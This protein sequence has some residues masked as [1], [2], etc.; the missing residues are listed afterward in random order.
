ME[1]V[2]HGLPLWAFTSVLK[3][4]VQLHSWK[5]HTSHWR[6]WGGARAGARGPLR[7][8]ILSFWHTKFSKRNCLGSPHPL[9]RGPRPPLREILDPPLHLIW[10]IHFT[11][12]DA[13]HF[14]YILQ[15]VYI[16]LCRSTHLMM[17]MNEIN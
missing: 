13:F 14:A 16:L 1:R 5:N 3:E 8:P 4:W 17:N 15:L 2:F 6:V 7:V 11:L 9:L 10:K 12:A